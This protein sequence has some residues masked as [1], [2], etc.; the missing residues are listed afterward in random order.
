MNLCV[1]TV[2]AA[3]MTYFQSSGMTLVRICK[4]DCDGK[5]QVH[6]INYNYQCPK[7]FK[8]KSGDKDINLY[9]MMKRP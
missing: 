9:D 3:T 6:R 7:R 8:I 1:L 5:R 2:V 4:Y